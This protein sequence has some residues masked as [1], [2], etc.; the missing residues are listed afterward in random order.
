M[1][2]FL[3]FLI[4]KIEGMVLLF[5]NTFYFGALKKVIDYGRNGENL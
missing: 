2:R 3:S 4:N 5:L 1:I